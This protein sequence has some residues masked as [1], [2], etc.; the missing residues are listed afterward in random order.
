METEDGDLRFN[1]EAYLTAIISRSEIVYKSDRVVRI[2]HVFSI[3]AKH[4]LENSSVYTFDV[5]FADKNIFLS[6]E[7]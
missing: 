5:S 4:F 6:Q 7:Q 1:L 2:M 3:K